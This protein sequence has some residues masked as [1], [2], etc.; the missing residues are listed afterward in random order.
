MNKNKRIDIILTGPLYYLITFLMIIAFIISSSNLIN[1]LFYYFLN[2]Q[3][4]VLSLF[5]SLMLF[6]IFSLLMSYDNDYSPVPTSGAILTVP[7]KNAAKI[8]SDFLKKEFK[9]LVF[10]LKFKNDLIQGLKHEKIHWKIS[11]KF[12][13]TALIQMKIEKHAEEEKPFFTSELWCN[14]YFPEVKLF[15]KF[16]PRYFVLEF[17]QTIFEFIWDLSRG[18]FFQNFHIRIQETFEGL[19]LK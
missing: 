19:R 5:L 1:L 4:L 17:I 6:F 16:Y 11:K 3:E 18:L 7:E 9:E 2:H 15:N 14:S 12:K 10:N 13:I 8:I